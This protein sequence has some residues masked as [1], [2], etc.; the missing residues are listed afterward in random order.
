MLLGESRRDDQTAVLTE[1]VGVPA[2]VLK[3]ES[4]I[5]R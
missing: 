2:D 1:S 4:E 5:A 3:A